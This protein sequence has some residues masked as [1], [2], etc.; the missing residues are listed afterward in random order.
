MLLYLADLYSTVPLAI[1]FSLFYTSVTNLRLDEI[2]LGLYLTIAN[3]LVWS[4]KRFPYPKNL[5]QI[6]R[7]PKDSTN[8]DYL[9]RNGKQSLDAPGFPSGHMTTI[10]F[11]C[12][13]QLLSS[14]YGKSINLSFTLFHIIIV[15]LMG[16]ARYYKRNHNIIQI[17]IGTIFGSL[18]GYIYYK[19][20]Q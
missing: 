7:R 4:I 2:K 8:C 19:Y 13:Y 18:S 9:S 1:Y 3:Y 5:Y 11:F 6:T 16:W 12:V 10:S 17:V 14:Y 15:G 20:L